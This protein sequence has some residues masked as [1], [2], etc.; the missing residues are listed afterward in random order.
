MALIVHGPYSYGLDNIKVKDWGEGA[1]LRIGS[2]CSIGAG[3][4]V[5]LGGNHNIEWVT[6]YPFGHIYQN[7]YPSDY[8]P[9]SSE[10]PSTK[11]DVVI[12]NDVWVGENVTI[13][14]GVTIGNGS[15]VG[16]GALVTKD[17]GDYCI[18]A[19]NPARFVRRRFD[20]E[21]INALQELAWWDLDIENIK[22]IIP[23]LQSRP[24]LATIN[25]IIRRFKDSP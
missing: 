5:Y 20:D 21:I 15:V 10:H 6:T 14:S 25:E 11:G 19:G 12:S 24:D 23:H 17:V 18:V 16:C 9:R 2:F 22:R 7:V 1:F 4:T 3:L 13:M 8:A